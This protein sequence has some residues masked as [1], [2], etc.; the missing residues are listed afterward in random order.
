MN[1]I[2]AFLFI[3]IF[4]VSCKLDTDKSKKQKFQKNLVLSYLLTNQSLAD[5]YSQVFYLDPLFLGSKNYN[6][7]PKANPTH[8]NSTK[9]KLILI[10]GWQPE[11]RNINSVPSEQDLKIR[12]VETI[13]KDLFNSNFL[14]QVISKG[15]DVYFYTYLT[16]AKIDENGHRLR[17]NLNLLFQS[18]IKNVFVYAH[19]MGGLVAKFAVD[20]DQEPNY[21]SK[22][23]T[24]GTPYH[25]SPWASSVFQAE[26]SI[27]GE[28][29]SYLAN[30]EGGKQL[31]WDNFNN[32]LSDANNKFLDSLNQNK[33]RNY[34]FYSY[35]GSL[36]PTASNY[37]GIDLFLLPACSALGNNFSPSDCIVPVSSAA[38][39]DFGFSKLTNL[40]NLN[41][42]DINL[43]I[44]SVQTQI[45]S[46]LD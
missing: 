43:R 17:I 8:V 40:G 23:Y 2:K 22:I 21:I 38:P 27:L 39:S 45:L 24:V 34:L 4:G 44:A 33:T 13:W 41:H 12:L 30:S 6:L 18:Q 42:T 14:T 5:H 29:A 10:H 7:F 36:N 32:S 1:F 19:S 46:D 20:L 11:D 26:K 28:L 37:S 16:T 35:Y 25:G 15:Y 9:K 31:A 3:L